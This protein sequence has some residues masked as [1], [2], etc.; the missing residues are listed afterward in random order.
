VTNRLNKKILA[1]L[2]LSAHN[3][4]V[5]NSTL[6]DNVTVVSGKATTAVAR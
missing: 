6:F 4:S 3:N 5:L 2:A 1:G